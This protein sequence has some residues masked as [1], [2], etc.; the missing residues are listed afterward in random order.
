MHLPTLLSLPPC[1]VDQG[2]ATIPTCFVRARIPLSYYPL[3]RKIIYFFLGKILLIIFRKRF[4]LSSTVF[5]GK[6]RIIGEK[7]EI[8]VCRKRYERVVDNWENS[9]EDFNLTRT[10]LGGIE[11]LWSVEPALNVMEYHEGVNYRN[12]KRSERYSR[13]YSRGVVAVLRIGR[14]CFIDWR[15]FISVMRL[16]GVW[17]IDIL[18]SVD[19]FRKNGY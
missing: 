7:K 10:T 6:K 4:R 5:I 16:D 17:T 1:A 2:S 14:I 3:V 13:V 9:R 8:S 12:G 11:D 19:N 18:G 15:S